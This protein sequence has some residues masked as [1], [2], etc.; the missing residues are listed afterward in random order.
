METYRE[1]LEAI[2][3][4]AQEQLRALVPEGA[5]PEQARLAVEAV[6]EQV[7]ALASVYGDAASYVAAELLERETGSAGGMLPLDQFEA[8][9]GSVRYAARHLFGDD[10]DPGAFAAYVAGALGKA[11]WDRAN[12]TMGQGRAGVRYARVP[13]GRETCAFCLM[14][15]GR[16][17]VYSSAEL[18]SHSHAGC[19]CVVVPV[20]KGGIGGY[21]YG[22]YSEMYY[23]SVQ[24]GPFGHVDL[25][26]TLAAMRRNYGLS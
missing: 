1:S 3:R 18:A 11:I 12:A 20:S 6:S 22:P 15:A 7:R 2:R 10:P 24:Y 21:D 26:A 16:G 19:D 23:R 4:T 9:D 13:T 5:T 17:Y 25:K 8:L 14:L